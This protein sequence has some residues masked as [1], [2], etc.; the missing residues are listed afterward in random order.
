MQDFKIVLD[1]PLDNDRKL[2]RVY[3]MR[4][5]LYREVERTARQEVDLEG[6]VTERF[7]NLWDSG[8]P[9]PEYVWLAATN[10]GVVG[11][12]TLMATSVIAEQAMDEDASL[13]AI[14]GFIETNLIAAGDGEAYARWQ[15]LAKKATAA[16]RDEFFAAVCFVLLEQH[17]V[18]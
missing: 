2:V 11:N 4:D 5:G 12:P 7:E 3:L 9:L 10:G 15:D 1:V 6:F 18:G 14:T 16:Q 8:T 13:T 17:S